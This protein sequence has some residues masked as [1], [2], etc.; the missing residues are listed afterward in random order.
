ML[1]F[2]SEYI[3]KKTP[4][5]YREII[6]VCIWKEFT[7]STI[8]FLTAGK[9]KKVPCSL[10]RKFNSGI[11]NF[12]QLANCLAKMWMKTVEKDTSN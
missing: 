4:K 9:K 6:Q 11:E 12:A 2:W 3:Y 7:D 1:N 10:S 5:N 8:L